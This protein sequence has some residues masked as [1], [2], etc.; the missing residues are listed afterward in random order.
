ML[1]LSSWVLSAVV[2]SYY[3][4]HTWKIKK[5]GGLKPRWFDGTSWRIRPRYS[6]SG[7]QHA[8]CESGTSARYT[9]E[10]HLECVELAVSLSV[11][12]RTWC[13]E[14]RRQNV[15]VM[16]S[17]PFSIVVYVTMVALTAVVTRLTVLPRE[18]RALFLSERIDFFRWWPIALSFFCDMWL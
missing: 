8:C 5:G 3:Y 16:S 13:L 11:R 12:H 15:L 14:R 10:L 2:Y 17:R 7:V 4:Q 18:E 9:N 1:K 6:G